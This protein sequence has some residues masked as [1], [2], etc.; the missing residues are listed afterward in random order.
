[1]STEPDD[2]DRTLLSAVE[3]PPPGYDLG[4]KVDAMEDR[5]L[6]GDPADAQDEK[7]ETDAEEEAPEPE[8]VDPSGGTPV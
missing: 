7:E 2:G 3:P 1:M 8:D 4:A 6:H 5:V